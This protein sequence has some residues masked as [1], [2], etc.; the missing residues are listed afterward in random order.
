MEKTA[1]LVRVGIEPATFRLKVHALTN[2]ATGADM[3]DFDAQGRIDVVAEALLR[4]AEAQVEVRRELERL[5]WDPGRV[6]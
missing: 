5:G 2:L 3:V 4:Y 6:S 1:I